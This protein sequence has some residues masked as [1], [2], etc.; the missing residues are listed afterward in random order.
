MN[1]PAQSPFAAANRFGV[2]LP[3]FAPAR[4]LVGA[5]NR[6]IDHRLFIVGIVG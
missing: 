3:L 5:H 2:W 4:L 1:L 6:R